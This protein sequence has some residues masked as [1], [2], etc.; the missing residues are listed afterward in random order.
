VDEVEDWAA[1]HRCDAEL[2]ALLAEVS[3]RAA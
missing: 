1:A 3:G 2:A